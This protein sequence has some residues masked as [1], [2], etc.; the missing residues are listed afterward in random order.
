MGVAMSYLWQRLF[1][2]N[3][4]KITMVGLDN[5]GKTTILYRLCAQCH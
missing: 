4:Y 5:A 3:E 2:S 1:G